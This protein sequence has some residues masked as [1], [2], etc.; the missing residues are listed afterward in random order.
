MNETKTSQYIS[1]SRLFTFLLMSYILYCLISGVYKHS[2]GL[3][4]CK[5][6]DH[7]CYCSKDKGIHV[8]CFSSNE[9]PKFLD[10]HQHINSFMLCICITYPTVH[11]QQ[12]KYPL[13]TPQENSEF[14]R[15]LNEH[16][17]LSSASI[18]GCFV[19]LPQEKQL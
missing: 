5:S 11:S 8:M 1:L 3:D 7:K 9:E 14:H 15:S 17:H 4:D 2:K 19:I 6:K 10:A 13:H 12:F 16:E 18:C